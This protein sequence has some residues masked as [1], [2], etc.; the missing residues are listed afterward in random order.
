MGAI[1]IDLAPYREC[2]IDEEGEAH[3][4]SWRHNE[5]GEDLHQD[6]RQKQATGCER[7]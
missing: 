1:L 5:L 3:V 2:V 6:G 7:P 4:T